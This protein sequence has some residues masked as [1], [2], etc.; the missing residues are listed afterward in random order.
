MSW[1]DGLRRA[2]VVEA[3]AEAALQRIPKATVSCSDMTGRPVRPEQADQA[4]ISSSVGNA[5]FLR[6]PRSGPIQAAF[7]EPIRHPEDV[8]VA[9]LLVLSSALE[10]ERA[11]GAEPSRWAAY[12]V[13]VEDVSMVRCTISA[14]DCTADSFQQIFADFEALMGQSLEDNHRWLMLG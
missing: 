9:V 2:A 4:S 8:P 5:P 6:L 7:E 3:F 11:I 13:L 10:V 12:E 1:F 14:S